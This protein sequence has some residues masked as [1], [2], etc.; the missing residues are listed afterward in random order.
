MT[1][2][3]HD[4]LEDAAR[5]ILDAI[6]EDPYREG[7]RE[8]PRRFA[9]WWREFVDY[10]PGNVDVTFEVTQVD[11]MVVVTGM[12]VW[13]V[14]EHHLMP[15]RCDVTVGYLTG[16]RVLGL[17]KFARIAHKCAHRLQLQERLVNDIADE[18]CATSGTQ[19]VAVVG[20]GEHL[21]MVMRGIRTPARMKTSV[22]RGRFLSKPEVRQEF[23]ALM[24]L[25]DT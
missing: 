8:T 18:V 3:K 19:D 16:P 11:Q 20:V 25:P 1:A 13:S 2:V 5:V 12:R 6:G 10:A 22:M 23:M 21:C 9:D 14:C 24:G 4:L 7:L 15:F 17:S